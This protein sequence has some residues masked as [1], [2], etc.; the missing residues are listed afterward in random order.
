MHYKSKINWSCSSGVEPL[1]SRHKALGSTLCT[2][3]IKQHKQTEKKKTEIGV[4]RNSK[5]VILLQ[6]DDK[7]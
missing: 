2:E 4:K 5:L 1:F 3:K 7:P 6:I